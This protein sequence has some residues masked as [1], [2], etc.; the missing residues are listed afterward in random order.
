MNE[1]RADSAF[2]THGS[3]GLGSMCLYQMRKAVTPCHR[4]DICSANEQEMSS[5]SMR[6]NKDPQCYKEVHV[7]V[8]FNC[9]GLILILF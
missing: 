9:V 3:V 5:P 6:L 1:S 7:S 4:D 2:I 8:G